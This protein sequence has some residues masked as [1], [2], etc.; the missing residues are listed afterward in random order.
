MKKLLFPASLFLLLLFALWGHLALERL[1]RPQP[2]YSELEPSFQLKYE[3]GPESLLTKS[4]KRIVSLAPSLTET[5]FALGLDAEVIG[6]TSFCAY[7]PEAAL[8]QTVAG[9]GDIYLEA[10]VRTRPDLVILPL[11]KT[12]NRLQMERL[13]LNTLALDTRTIFGLMQSIEILG[14][15]AQHQKQAAALLESINKNLATAQAKAKG[16]KRPRV[17]FSVMHAYQ[18]LGYISEISVIGNDGFYSELI[19]LAGGQNAY[20]GSLPFPRL[21]REA[22]IFLDPE[23]IIDVIPPGEDLEAV[24]QD[25]QSLSSVSAIKNNRLLL[26]TDE[27]HTVPGP[28]FVQTLQIMSQEFHPQEPYP[29][30]LNSEFNF[31][32][33]PNST[34]RQE[35]SQ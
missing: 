19:E 3:P 11:D 6:V 35:L 32:G 13:G 27:A 33:G 5:L 8:K 17:L 20:R 34:P 21:S 30:N 22:I 4:P 1:T 2:I 18:G 12:W 31:N 16:R 26:L 24:R 14:Q 10:L 23:V 28:R 29:Q 7:P 25:W 9:F 15:S